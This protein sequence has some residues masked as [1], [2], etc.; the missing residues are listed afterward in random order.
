MVTLGQAVSYKVGELKM[1]D[2]RERAKK[3]LRSKFDI[4]AFLDVVLEDGCLPLSILEAKVN[5]WINKMS[6]K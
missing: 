2:L 4:K 5:G 3:T 1:I 6:P